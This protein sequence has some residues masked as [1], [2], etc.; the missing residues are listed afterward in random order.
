LLSAGVGEGI[1]FAGRNHVAIKI[2]ASRG[3]HRLITSNP[4]EISKMK[5]QNI[6]LSEEDIAESAL[7]YE[8]GTE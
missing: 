2:I 8:P 3:E 7:I 1:F 5:A 6:E 4:K